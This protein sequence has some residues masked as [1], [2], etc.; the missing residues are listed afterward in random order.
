[1][2][3]PFRFVA[4]AALAG[5][6]VV[7][8]GTASAAEVNLYSSRQPFLMKPLLD[9][10]SKQSGIKVNM[11]YMKKGMLERLKAE[12]ANSPADL[13]LTADI[14]N[15]HNHAKADLLQPVQ[16]AILDSNIPAQ[17][18][19]PDGLW[20]GLT[21]RARVI[22]ADKKRVKPGE[23]K[24][25][26]DLAAPHMKGRVCI[27]SGKHVYNVSLLA[28]IVMAK[29]KEAARAW[30]KGLRANLA[31]KPQ[32][33]DRAQVKA[34]Y[35]GVCDVAV[36]NTYYMGK[37]ATNKKDPEQKKWAASVN[38]IFPNQQDRGT[39]VN[40][41]GAGITRSAKN[42]AAALKLVE[43]LSGAAAQKIYAERNFEYPVK[44]G[45]PL[46]PLVA[47]WGSFKAD[48]EF[49]AKIAEQRTTA[50]RIM[51]QVAFNR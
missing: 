36:G 14:G 45:V 1:M 22:F 26:E 39:H 25:Y 18:R 30:A 46:H 4:A 17:Y 32:G 48:E 29:G 33:N 24:S 44:A 13:V 15:L 41:S 31:R 12:G 8:A 42:K 5:A 49:L 7:A 10:F 35:Q 27:R 40:I 51:D 50:S 38:L 3:T 28:S 16:S 34:V 20:Y 2:K 21:M 19:H 37:M 23:V 11:V 9:A 6:V 43:F 47:S